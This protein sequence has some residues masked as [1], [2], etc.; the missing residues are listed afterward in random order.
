VA[1]GFAFRD[2]LQPGWYPDSLTE[3]FQIDDQIVF[4]DFEGTVEIQTRA[5]TIRTYD[6]RRIVIP[7][8]ELLLIRLR[9]TPPSNTADR[10]MSASATAT[11]STWRSS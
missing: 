1:I 10:S 7:N 6:G 8:S 5:T 4:T 9:L 11:T 2:I 3:P